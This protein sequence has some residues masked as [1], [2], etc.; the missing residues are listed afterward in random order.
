MPYLR[1]ISYLIDAR[2]SAAVQTDRREAGVA[3]LI[4]KMLEESRLHFGCR[5][6]QVFVQSN[7]LI[8][9]E[10]IC[11]LTLSDAVAAMLRAVVQMSLHVYYDVFSINLYRSFG[12]DSIIVAAML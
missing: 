2:A 12:M 7:G 5:Y 3:I 10:D 6:V 1:G 11:S 8:L 4:L 9:K